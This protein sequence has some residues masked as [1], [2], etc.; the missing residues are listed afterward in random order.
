MCPLEDIC[1]NMTTILSLH[2]G[3]SGVTGGEGG[4]VPPKTSDRGKFCWPTGK[5]EA[6]KKGESGE[7]WE[8]KK[9]NIIKGRWKIEN[10]RWKF[11]K[12]G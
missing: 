10:G 6:R 4:T 1:E 8:E 9:E 7:N 12:W 3:V 5:E 2:S 11:T